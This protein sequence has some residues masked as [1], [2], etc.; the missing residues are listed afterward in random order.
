MGMT[1]GR[2]WIVVLGVLLGGIVALN[3]WGLSL[4]AA[5]STTA[6]KIDSYERQN[7]ILRGRIATKLS[8]DKVEAAATSLGLAVPAADQVEYLKVSDNDVRRAAKRLSE[9]AIAAVATA[10]TPPPDPAID[11]ITGAPVDPAADPTLTAPTTDTTATTVT[12]ATDT[13]ADPTVTPTDTATTDP[14]TPDPAA[15]DTVTSDTAATTTPPP[16]SS[17]PAAGA[18]AP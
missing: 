13:A 15:T 12:T 10:V 9:G 11:P 3:V 8:N 14:V 18:V 1:R 2:A 7:S 6:G 5:S 16:T 17:D 4:N